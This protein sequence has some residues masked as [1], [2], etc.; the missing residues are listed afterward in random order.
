MKMYLVKN[1]LAGSRPFFLSAFFACDRMH[2]VLDRFFKATKIISGY[3]E[4]K[5]VQMVFRLF[6]DIC[7]VLLKPLY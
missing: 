1:T 4:P 5:E 3:I 2:P 6:L 7:Y